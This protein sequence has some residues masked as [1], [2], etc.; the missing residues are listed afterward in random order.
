MRANENGPVTLLMMM[1]DLGAAAFDTVNH[2]IL[3]EVQ[4]SR[5]GVNGLA[6]DWFRSYL[7]ERTKALTYQGKQTVSCKGPSRVPILRPVEFIAYLQDITEVT[8][9]CNRIFTLPTFSRLYYCIQY[10]VR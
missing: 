8:V 6:S 7:S 4:S 5:F 3:L 1:L 9:Q 10:N 2:D